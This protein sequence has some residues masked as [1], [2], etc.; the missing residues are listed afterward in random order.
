MLCKQ[1]DDRLERLHPE[2]EGHLPLDE[3]SGVMPEEVEEA[4][5]VH[6]RQAMPQT[7]EKTATRAAAIHAAP[8]CLNCRGDCEPERQQLA[9]ETGTL[10]SPSLS[11][12]HV[13]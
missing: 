11:P 13:R 4:L 12:C 3:R 7:V 1:L 6:R 9:V 2:T 10:L 8:I 5:V